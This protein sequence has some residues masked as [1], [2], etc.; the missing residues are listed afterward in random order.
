[1][2]KPTVVNNYSSGFSALGVLGI[3]FVLCKIFG[4]MPI[5]GW[6][7]WI[8]LLPFYVGLAF[9]F[10]VFVAVTGIAIFG[11]VVAGVAWLLAYV[12]DWNTN[13]KRRNANA[14]RLAEYKQRGRNRGS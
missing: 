12:L 7:W 2:S 1:M 3:I 13:R 14:S 9:V 11:L 6:S 4:I 8:V 10:G 5:A